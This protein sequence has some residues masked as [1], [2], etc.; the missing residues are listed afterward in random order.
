MMLGQVQQL[1]L[2]LC[3]TYGVGQQI[4]RLPEQLIALNQ[5]FMGESLIRRAITTILKLS[6]NGVGCS[7]RT[8]T[9][10]SEVIDGQVQQRQT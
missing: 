6:E 3:P 8:N 9:Q 7:G 5:D 10:Q 4:R 2:V 1:R